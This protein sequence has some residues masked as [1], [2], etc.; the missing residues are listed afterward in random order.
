MDLERL[1]TSGGC[2]VSAAFFLTLAVF[3]V[4]GYYLTDVLG[5]AQGQYFAP[6]GIV[7]GAV[8]AVGFRRRSRP[9]LAVAGV[10]MLIAGAALAGVSLFDFVR[11]LFTGESFLASGQ[12]SAYNYG[13]SMFLMTAIGLT[14][15]V[16]GW[17]LTRQRR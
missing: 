3:G 13:V 6:I 10:F 12:Y 5:I 8:M 11:R 7:V 14:I 15:A 17:Y 2:A 16:F 9:V 4:L 1:N